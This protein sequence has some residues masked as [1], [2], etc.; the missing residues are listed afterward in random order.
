MGMFING[1]KTKT[2]RIGV[3]D[4]D[5]PATTLKGNTLETVEAFS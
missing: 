2:M 3:D 1:T 4:G 5:Q